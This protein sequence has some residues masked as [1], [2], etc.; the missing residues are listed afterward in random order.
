M[1]PIYDYI[2][3]G[4]GLSG[5]LMAYRMAQDPWF[6][7]KSIL[8]LEKDLQKGNDRTW[9]FWEPLGGE[10]DDIIHKT[11]NKAFIGN[12]SFEKVHDLE[13]FQYKMIRS[14]DFYNKTKGVISKK[15]N[16]EC[17]FDSIEKWIESGDKILIQGKKDHY[18]A[19]YVLNSIFNPDD[20][21]D[22]KKYPYLKQHFV[23][24]FIKTKQ[25][26]FNPDVVH[27][28]DFT[29]PQKGNTRFMYV[30]PT[31]KTE[32]LV[33]YTLFSEDLLTKQEYETALEDY[34]KEL[35]IQEYEIVETEQGNIPMTCYPLHQKN[36][37]RMMYIGTAGGWTKPSTGYTFY[38]SLKLSTE[39]LQFLKSGKTLEKFKISS[40]Y[41]WYDLILLEVLHRHNEKG[42]ELFGMMFEKINI[43]EIFTFLNE[44]GT[45]GSD[46]KIINAM[47]KGIFTLAFIKSFKKLLFN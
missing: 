5:L 18:E 23:G 35:G 3:I 20:L 8:I 39:L 24:W 43:K 31:S 32:A 17:K 12:A 47:P 19:T 22:Q 13:P 45:L 37:K 29:I 21:L 46:L 15:S 6:D 36:T 2:I 4:S 7:S 11:W 40:R 25:E 27:F 16:I 30:L 1:K 10:F 34:L 41:W 26:V 9:C 38:N 33:E 44:D 14:A 42:G 28:M